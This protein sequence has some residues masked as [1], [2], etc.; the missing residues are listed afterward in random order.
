[1]SGSS[2][3]TVSEFLPLIRGCPRLAV[4]IRKAAENRFGFS[5]YLPRSPAGQSVGISTEGVGI[6]SNVTL[7]TYVRKKTSSRNADENES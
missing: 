4:L 5:G 1:M 2:S 6:G 3:T 7:W